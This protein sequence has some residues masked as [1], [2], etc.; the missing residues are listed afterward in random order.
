MKLG[1]HHGV[2]KAGP[3]EVSQPHIGHLAREKTVGGQCP[4]SI[5]IY[6]LTFIIYL[7][8]FV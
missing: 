1:R 4:V 6:L 8:G 2:K 5:V 7:F 3:Q